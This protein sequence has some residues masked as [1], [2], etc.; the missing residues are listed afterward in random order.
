MFASSRISRRPQRGRTA[1]PRIQKRRTE[2]PALQDRTGEQ[3][4]GHTVP[5]PRPTPPGGPKEKI[6]SLRTRSF[7][8]Q[9]RHE[10]LARASSCGL[11]VSQQ[12][13]QHLL[14]Q[15]STFHLIQLPW[16]TLINYWWRCYGSSVTGTRRTDVTSL[17]LKPAVRGKAITLR[18]AKRL[19]THDRLVACRRFSR[20]RSLN[21]ARRVS[22]LI[23]G[24]DHPCG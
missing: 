10:L 24:W 23:Q 14:Y 5:S 9:R 13:R 8:T 4:A 1:T 22:P 17:A 2:I 21:F 15:L 11:T 12:W 20:P 18:T 6:G 7:P 16:C 19:D 3:G